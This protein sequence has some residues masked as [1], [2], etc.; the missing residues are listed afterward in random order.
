MEC[1]DDDECCCAIWLDDVNNNSANIS[2]CGVASGGMGICFGDDSCGNSFVGSQITKFFTLTD[3]RLDFC[4]NENSPFSVTNGS[5]ANTAYV[6][7]SCQRGLTFPQVIQLILD[8]AESIY[9]ETD[10]ACII[11]EC[12]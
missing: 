12:P 8:P 11:T 6:Y 7:I 2:V 5:G 9:F 4:M 10:D 3:Q 1:P